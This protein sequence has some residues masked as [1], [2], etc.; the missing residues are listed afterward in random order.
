MV[1]ADDPCVNPGGDPVLLQMIELYRPFR[2]SIV[3][4]QAVLRE[5]TQKYGVIAGEMIRDDLYRV[6]HMVEKPKPEETSSNLA[7]IVRYIL[8][9]DIFLLIVDTEPGKGGEIQITDALMEQA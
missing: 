7:I 6:S 3:E 2:C 4:I 9:P 5:E 1:L 8:I